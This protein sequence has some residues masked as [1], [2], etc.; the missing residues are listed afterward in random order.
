MDVIQCHD[1]PLNVVPDCETVEEG[2]SN[3]V[4]PHKQVSFLS[5]LG[6]NM[7][8]L[9]WKEYQMTGWLHIVGSNIESYP[10]NSEPTPNHQVH[11]FMYSNLPPNATLPTKCTS[12]PGISPM[13]TSSTN[14][15]LT[16][17]IGTG[18]ASPYIL[19]E[20]AAKSSQEADTN[21]YYNCYKYIPC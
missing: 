8:H 13:P 7:Y 11:Q 19:S 5:F 3:T 4:L 16:K 2:V 21:P 14:S 6:H 10:P 17:Y 9:Q 1:I 18:V 12:P 20:S 15:Y